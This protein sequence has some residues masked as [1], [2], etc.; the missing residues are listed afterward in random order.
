MS[1]TTTAPQG[2]SLS[3]R[4]YTE[5]VDF[6]GRIAKSSMV[7]KDYQGRPDNI[8]LAIQLGA[9]LGLAPLQSLQNIS[10][11]GGRP[12]V[13]GDAMIGLCRKSPICEDII[14]T[15]DGEGDAMEAVCIARRVGKKSVE[16]RFSVADAKK[17]SLWGKAGPWQQYPKRMLQMR[18][19]GFAL[20]DAFPDVLKGLITVEEAMDMPFT[21]T[22]I[23]ATS[24]R[25]ATNTEVPLKA[26]AAA[27][28]RPDRIVEAAPPQPKQTIGQYLEAFEIAMQDCGTLAAVNR[29]ISSP[30]TVQAKQNLK[31]DALERLERIIA[32]GLAAHAPITYPEADDEELPEDER[33]DEPVV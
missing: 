23:E 1:V 17:A 18:A 4:S 15:L 12:A 10:V 21:G 14:E 9:E 11:I 16:Q 31:G 8:I 32:A 2:I 26:A 33:A 7:P 29:L 22:T 5:L 20:R 27:T 13:W 25:E 28:P 6:A 3:P 24:E 19:R 30:K